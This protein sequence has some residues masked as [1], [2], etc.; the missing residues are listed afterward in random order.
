MFT[1]GELHL[2]VTAYLRHSEK[3]FFFFLIKGED[4]QITLVNHF[5]GLN[6][7]PYWKIV[8]ECAASEIFK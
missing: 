6:L 4:L 2:V 5:Q 7:Y 8:T 1:L 3:L